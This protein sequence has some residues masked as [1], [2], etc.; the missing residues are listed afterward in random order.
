MPNAAASRVLVVVADGSESLEAVTVINVLRRGGV[1]VQ[2]AGIGP[3]RVIAGTRGIRFVADVHHADVAEESWDLLVL[4]GGEPGAR[5]LAAHAPL[6]AQLRARLAANQP[7]AA[8]CA[9]PALVLAAHGLLDGRRATGYPTFRALMPDWQDQAVVDDGVL[10]TS[11]GPGTAIAFALVLLA[12]LAGRETRDSVAG[13][14][15]VG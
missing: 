6:I 15:L 2:V 12:R 11:Q 9:A 4:P 14:L 1:E 7:V 13:A 10:I 8:I 5:A 3:D